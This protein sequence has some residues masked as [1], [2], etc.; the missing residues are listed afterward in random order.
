MDLTTIVS[1]LVVAIFFLAAAGWWLYGRWWWEQW[2]MEGK[3]R[4]YEKHH[5]NSHLRRS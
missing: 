3:V 1:G 4:E 5:Q 2:K